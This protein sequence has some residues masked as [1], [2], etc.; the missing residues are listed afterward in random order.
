MS[1]TKN[2]SL[3]LISIRIIDQQKKL[4][5]T[6]TGFSCFRIDRVMQLLIF[7]TG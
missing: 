1:S 5:V 7:L 6:S 3:F 2:Q 4:S